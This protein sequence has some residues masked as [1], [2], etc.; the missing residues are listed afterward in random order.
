M[1]LQAGGVKIIHTLNFLPMSL[2]EFTTAFGVHN[3][4]KGY[5]PN[6]FKRGRDS[7]GTMLVPYQMQHEG[8]TMKEKERA[9]FLK[10]YGEVKDAVFRFSERVA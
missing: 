4:K 1:S 2:A 10:W 5:F 7:I 9:A 3:L 8:N 6:F